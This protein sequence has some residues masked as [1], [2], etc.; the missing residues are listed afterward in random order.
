MESVFEI[1]AR[2]RSVRAFL[3]EQL[4]EEE[5]QMILAA[6]RNAPSGGNSRTTHLLVLQNPDVLAKLRDTVEEAFA[7]MEV[8]EGAYASIQNSVR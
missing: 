1:M 4:K 2:R 8:D 7:K 5:L 3:P 6:G